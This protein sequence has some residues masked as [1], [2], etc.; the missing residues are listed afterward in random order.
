M[1]S[2][3]LEK[4]EVNELILGTINGEEVTLKDAFPSLLEFVKLRRAN[5]TGDKK[6]LKAFF[7][8]FHGQPQVTFKYGKEYAV[9]NLEIATKEERD[10][11]KLY[12]YK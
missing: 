4:R 1:E 9:F 5:Y 10:Y 7:N 6:E 2:Q 8:V 11:N 12:N 3:V